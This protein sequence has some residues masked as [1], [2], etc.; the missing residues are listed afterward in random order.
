M[1]RMGRIR[2][3]TGFMLLHRPLRYVLEGAHS[4]F[5]GAQA[6]ILGFNHLTSFGMGLELDSSAYELYVTRA[7]VVGR[8]IFGQNIR[9]FSIGL[10]VSF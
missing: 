1:L 2:A 8:Y 10:A 6:G 3:P 9:G 4:T 7:R 5:F